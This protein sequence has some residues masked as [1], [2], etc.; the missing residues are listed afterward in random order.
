GAGERLHRVAAGRGRGAGAGAGARGAD[1]T[2]V[3]KKILIIEDEPDIVR[4][5]RDALEFEGF[6]VLATEEGREGVKLARER[7]PDCVILDLML[8][9]VNGYAVCEEL[10]A[11]N[12]VLP[13]IMLTARSQE[14]DKIRGLEAGADDYVTK[15]FSISD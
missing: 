8:G 10:R 5:L 15:P 11:Q 14:S 2:F 6:D 7:A 4:G 3:R 12:S 1:M 13:I 9:D